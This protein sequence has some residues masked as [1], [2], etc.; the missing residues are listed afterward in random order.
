MRVRDPP[1][2]AVP[3]P[4]AEEHL[5]AVAAPDAVLLERVREE[6][7]GGGV[8]HGEVA[9]PLVERD[10]LRRE[11]RRDEN[12]SPSVACS[13]DSGPSVGVPN[14]AL[15]IRRRRRLRVHAR[16]REDRERRRDAPPRGDA[17]LEDRPFEVRGADARR[18]ADARRL[19][20]GLHEEPVGAEAGRDGEQAEGQIH[21]RVRRDVDDA[22]V[23]RVD[24]RVAARRLSEHG[25]VPLAR[26]NVER[27]GVATRW[28]R[29]R[30]RRG[31]SRA[32]RSPRLANDARRGA[33]SATSL[34]ERRGHRAEARVEIVHVVTNPRDDVDDRAVVELAR[35][36][37]IE[38]LER[39]ARRF[40]ARERRNRD[41]GP[42]ASGSL[43]PRKTASSDSRGRSAD[44]TFAW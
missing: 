10:D 37:Q 42:R 9:H 21:R 39:G 35:V 25:D 13:A 31:Q 43:E 41:R 2:E 18:R 26:R 44:C 6:R 15:R 19:P 14:T 4:L 29:S 33:R 22:R 30:R 38:A 34:I 11:R 32:P 8:A 40:A 27:A 28:R 24:V 20:A 5:H 17:R 16:G 1:E 7:R 23:P 12:K 3:R 36:M